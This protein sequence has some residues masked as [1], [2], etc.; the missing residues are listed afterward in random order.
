MTHIHE[1]AV[2][3]QE[4]S[5]YTEPATTTA[6]SGFT[7]E[8]SS[9]KQHSPQH[10]TRRFWMALWKDVGRQTQHLSV[11]S[12]FRIEKRW[13]GTEMGF[14]DRIAALAKKAMLSPG[15]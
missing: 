10:S 12:T 15:V 13:K 7:V 5:S 9:M 11:E 1:G 3:F 14:E 8:A 2:A 4:C 6:V